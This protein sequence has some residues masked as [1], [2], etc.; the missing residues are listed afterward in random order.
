MT[1]SY[2]RPGHNKYDL[3]YSILDRKP[4]Y[5]EGFRWGS[6]DFSHVFEDL[7]VEVSLLGPD[8]AFLRGDP[9]VRWDIIPPDKLLFP[10]RVGRHPRAALAPEA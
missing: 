3:K 6:Q 9:A 10:K 7:Y 8:P 5:V 4:T 1:G 2:S